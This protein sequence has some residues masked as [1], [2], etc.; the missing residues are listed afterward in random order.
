MVLG[1]GAASAGSSG[2]YRLGGRQSAAEAGGPVT[3]WQEVPHV[4]EGA[5]APDK[6]IRGMAVRANWS[7]AK[8]EIPQTEPCLRLIHVGQWLLRDSAPLEFLIE[9]LQR[10]AKVQLG[11]SMSS[12]C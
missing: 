5:T 11:W 3:N 4:K 8:C 12:S 10:P 6:G 7:S 9:P 2:P 1:Q